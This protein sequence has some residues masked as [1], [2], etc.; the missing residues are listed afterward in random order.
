M[1]DA[2][3]FGSD[4]DLVRLR[5]VVL[6][7]GA[8]AVGQILGNYCLDE[9]EVTLLALRRRGKRSIEPEPDM[10]LEEGDVRVLQGGGV[11][12]VAAEERL[13]HGK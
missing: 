1:S 6:N 12:L 5:S 11:A 2:G 3:E 10:L 7:T 13:L 4:A 9:L 8:H